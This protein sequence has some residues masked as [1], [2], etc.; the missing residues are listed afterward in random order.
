MPSEK[1]VVIEYLFQKHWDSAAKKLTKAESP[2]PAFTASFP[3]GVAP[4]ALQ[5]AANVNQSA[6][7][8]LTRRLARLRLA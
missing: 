3:N 6:A 1:T 8:K 5:L 2:S 7:A 4:L